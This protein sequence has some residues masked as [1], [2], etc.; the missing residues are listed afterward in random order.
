M[1]HDFSCVFASVLVL[2]T[3]RLTVVSRRQKPRE[4]KDNERETETEIG[5]RN[6]E[7]TKRREKV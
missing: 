7:R 3:H 1:V 6:K 2:Q 4:K 5:S